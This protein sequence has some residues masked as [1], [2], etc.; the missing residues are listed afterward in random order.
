MR[1]IVLGS[2]GIGRIHIREYIKNDIDK[3]GI[4]N[5]KTES[6]KNAAE[7]LSAEYSKKI[8]GYE[9]IEQI[10]SL[11][12]VL[13]SICIP[14]ALHLKYATEL[15]KAGSYILVEKPLFWDNNLNG[16]QIIESCEKIFD[17]SENKLR[18]N[19]PSATLTS[20]LKQST[21]IHGEINFFNLSYYT[22]GNYSGRDIGVDLLPHALSA[23]S[24]F[25][26]ERQINPEHI[27]IKRIHSDTGQW[28]FEG[29]IM[30]I[31]CIFDFQQGEKIKKTRLSININNEKYVRRQYIDN[32]GDMVVGMVVDSSQEEIN[33]GNPMSLNIK[34][35]IDTSRNRGKFINEREHVMNIIKSMVKILAD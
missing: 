11:K 7:K 20:Q 6:T 22:K 12:P 10:C 23:L 15:L 5:S 24:S 17:I 35:F 8:I 4:L 27:K 32:L 9:S 14:N 21:D 13:V 28:S 26:P 29:E 16:N 1:G 2:S 18:V 30:G 34:N 31:K 3:I 19:H 33:V 25:I